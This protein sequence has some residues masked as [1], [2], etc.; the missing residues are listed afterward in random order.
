MPFESGSFTLSVF[1]IYE[2]IPGNALEL[3]AAR[4]AGKLDEVKEEP[5]VGWVSG[6]QLLDRRIEEETAVVGAGYIYLQLRFAQRK[7]PASLLKAECGMEEMAY[8]KA[9]SCVDIPR[10]VKKEI[11]KSVMER[12]LPQ[13]APQFSGIPMVLDRGSK[14]LYMGASS[15]KQIDMFNGFFLET[16]K[17]KLTQLNQDLIFVENKMDVCSYKGMTLAQ[18]EGDEM[19]PMRDFL[20]WLWYFSEEEKGEIAVD[21]HG[22]FAVTLDGPLCF[23][24]DGKGALESVVRKGNPLRSAEALTALKVGKKMRKAKIIMAKNNLIWSAVFDADKFSFSSVALP[25]GEEMEAGERFTE[26]MEHVR[27]FIAVLR[28]LFAKF[29]AETEAIS[30]KDKTRKI[31]AWVESRESF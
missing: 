13:M 29:L 16:L 11:R 17:I 1:H 22:D 28:A 19:F 21:D 15:Q 30:W 3:F 24:A 10:K 5:Q 25:E 6:R 27:D 23:V 20:T 18:G 12:L 8:S 26:R 2:D 4:S 7:I 31:M 9:S 14:V